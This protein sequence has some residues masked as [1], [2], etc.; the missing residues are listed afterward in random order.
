MKI[1]EV[2]LEIFSV[3]IAEVVQG[4]K[5]QIEIVAGIMVEATG[6]VISGFGS[7][8]MGRNR[9]REILLNAGY[10]TI[11]MKNS[12]QQKFDLPSRRAPSNMN[13]VDV[14]WLSR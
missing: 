10:Q 4:T 3:R 9:H 8:L 5:E 6:K 7:S 2:S 13:S 12:F 14:V 11:E 1:I